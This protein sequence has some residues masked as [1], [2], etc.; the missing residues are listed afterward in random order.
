MVSYASSSSTKSTLTRA[1]TLPQFVIYAGVLSLLY[2]TP[3]PVSPS[4][5][6]APSAAAVCTA[7]VSYFRA[8]NINP[9]MCSAHI[10]EVPPEQWL[11]SRFTS[12]SI[13]TSVGTNFFTC[14][15]SMDTGIFS[16][17]GGM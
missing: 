12:H 4:T 9:L 14:N 13:L 6:I 15:G 7:A 17:E 1:T 11:C 5:A 2:S 8:S 16:P 10:P 3:P